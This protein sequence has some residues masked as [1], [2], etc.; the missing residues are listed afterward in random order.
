MAYAGVPA[1]LVAYGPKG[2]YPARG[3]SWTPV[4]RDILPDFFEVRLGA[5]RDARPAHPRFRLGFLASIRFS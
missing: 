1:R 2:R 4:L 5:A 3:G